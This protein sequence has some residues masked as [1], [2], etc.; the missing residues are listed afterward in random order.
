MKFIAAFLTVV[1]V[2]AFASSNLPF[3]NYYGQ[4]EVT[5]CKKI[6]SK[7][8][9]ID[10][11]SSKEILIVKAPACGGI[12]SHTNIYF[13]SPGQNFN[14]TCTSKANVNNPTSEMF[15][16]G[17]DLSAEFYRYNQEEDGSDHYFIRMTKN[18]KSYVF[19]DF[20]L[21]KNTDQTLTSKFKR[22]ETS[23]DDTNDIKSSFEFEIT[24]KPIK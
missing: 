5:S 8:N 9:A 19:T 15:I 2:S 18:E 12:A 3:T 22:R 14:N 1:S 20:W 4:Y 10:L 7:N 13:A 17:E 24:M 21:K 6:D 16:T 11:C 23:L